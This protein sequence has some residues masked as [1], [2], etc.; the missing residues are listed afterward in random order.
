M[1]ILGD[2]AAAPTGSPDGGTP[3]GGREVP[4]KPIPR[5]KALTTADD[6]VSGAGHLQ[7]IDRYA[8]ALAVGQ[9]RSWRNGLLIQ[10]E[11]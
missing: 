11:I 6:R 3:E 2:S 10:T 7:P 4:V 1:C 8:R 5:R 9:K